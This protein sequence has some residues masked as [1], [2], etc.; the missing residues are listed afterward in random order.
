MSII[1]IIPARFDST[2]FPGKPLADINGKSMIQRVYEQALKVDSLNKVVVATDDDRIFNHCSSLNINVVM[3]SNSHRN[4]TER[5]IEVVKKESQSFDFVLN[6][7]G[8]EPFV[9]PV[10]IQSLCD[11]MITGKYDIATLAKRIDNKEEKDNSNTVKLVKSIGGRALYFSRYSIPFDRNNTKPNMF[12]H[13]GMYAFKTNVLLEIENIKPT[14]LEVSESLEQLRWLEND[15]TIGV[16]E[17][18]YESYGIDT[19]EDITNA[20]QNINN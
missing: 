1:A 15:Y 2:R 18:E 6:I 20:L 14:A 19:P 5:I 16:A 7:Q 11:L 13:I 3:T 8:D 17:T 12:K 9:H 10:Q 4:G